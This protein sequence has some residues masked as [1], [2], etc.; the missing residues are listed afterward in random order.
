MVAVLSPRDTLAHDDKSIEESNGVNVINQNNIDDNVMMKNLLSL[1]KKSQNNSD[2]S[3]E[4]VK[5]DSSIDEEDCDVS[6]EGRGVILDLSNVPE[7]NIDLNKFNY[8]VILGFVSKGNSLV[9]YVIP[10]QK[11]SNYFCL[12]LQPPMLLMLQLRLEL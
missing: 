8:D 7:E 12:N 2:K 3:S 6:V 9:T 1:T 11:K 4:L 10:P 5:E